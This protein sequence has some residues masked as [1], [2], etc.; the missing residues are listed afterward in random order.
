MRT[1][2]RGLALLLVQRQQLADR[3]LH[4]EHTHHVLRGHSVLLQLPPD[5]L[6]Q[7]V[8]FIGLVIISSAVLE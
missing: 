2:L 6:R 7:W 5:L 8:C 3:L 1:Y 4:A